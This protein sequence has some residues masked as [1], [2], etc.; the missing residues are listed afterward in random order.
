MAA[1]CAR[2]LAGLRNRALLLLLAEAS[3]NRSTLTGLQAEHVRFTASGVELREDSDGAPRL[4]M[5]LDASLRLRFPRKRR[6]SA[7]QSPKEGCRRSET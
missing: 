6:R 4:V 5:S 2:D 1:S 7:Q 3:L